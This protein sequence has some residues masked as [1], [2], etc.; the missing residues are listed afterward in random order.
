MVIIYKIVHRLCIDKIILTIEA[1]WFLMEPN[2]KEEFMTTHIP[3]NK[4]KSNLKTKAI[5][6]N[7]MSLI[8]KIENI[9]RDFVMM[10]QV[11]LPEKQCFLV[12][13]KR[14]IKEIIHSF[15]FAECCLEFSHKH[16]TGRK[17]RQLGDFTKTLSWVMDLLSCELA[18]I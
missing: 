14:V 18:H 17:A 16:Y 8:E 12:E 15:C 1:L 11:K 3:K 9:L 13:L 2:P 4:R 10:F 7:A 5:S 6:I